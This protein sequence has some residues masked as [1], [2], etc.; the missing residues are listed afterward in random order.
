MKS[1]SSKVLQMLVALSSQDQ[2][3]VNAFWGLDSAPAKA[4]RSV[5]PVFD[6]FVHGSGHFPAL[7]IDEIINSYGSQ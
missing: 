6:E 7:S 1:F 2:H 4:S 3:L 5:L